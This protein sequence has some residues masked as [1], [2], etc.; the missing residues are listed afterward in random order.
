MAVRWWEE[1]RVVG[2]CSSADGECKIP[3]KGYHTCQAIPVSFF[4]LVHLMLFFSSSQCTQ[5]VDNV[6]MAVPGL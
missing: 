1:L 3:K 2:L 5:N 4:P 6:G